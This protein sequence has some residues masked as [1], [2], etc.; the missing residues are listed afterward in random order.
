M[1]IIINLIKE[2]DNIKMYSFYYYRL[3]KIKARE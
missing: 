2:E 3:L 1:F